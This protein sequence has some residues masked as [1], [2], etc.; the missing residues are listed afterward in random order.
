MPLSRKNTA[1]SLFAIVVIIAVSVV[2]YKYRGLIRMKMLEFLHS[3]DDEVAVAE[4][5]GPPGAWWKARESSFAGSDSLSPLERE[6][7]DLLRSIGYLPGYEEAPVDFGVTLYD[8][9]LTSD[10]Y[11]LIISGHGPGISLVDMN[12]EEVHT[13]FN[14]SVTIDRLWPEAQ[15]KELPFEFWRRAHLYPN[16]DLL[17]MIEACGIIL[18]NKDSDLLWYSQWN[19]AHHD[20]DID[21]EGNIYTIGRY[22]HEN[23][24]Y[25]PDKIIAEDYIIRLD[26]LGNET[27]RLST[28]DVLASSRYAPVL[29]DMPDGGDVLHCN[30]IEF[31]RPDMLP[32]GYSGPFRPGSV[33]LSHRTIDLVCA[34]D[35]E[36]ETVYWAE[37]DLWDMQ[38]Q[39][40]LMPDGTMMVLDNQGYNHLEEEQSTVIQFDPATGERIWY[41]QGD[42]EHPFYTIGSGS[43]QRLPNGNT[44]IVESM[45]GRAFEVTPDKQIVWEFYNPHR[46]GENN[47]L[48]ATLFDLVR[49]PSSS[50]DGWLE[51]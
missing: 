24:D 1:I 47:E 36:E 39:P 22:I 6:Q 51:R 25:F 21:G 33:L 15:D 38:H 46:A 9:S 7:I 30:T 26:S 49:I 19:G 20:V 35:L 41:Y 3:F 10:G 14:S 45:M 2:G 4:E 32:E 5:E 17:V 28:L 40:N 34:V 42:S 44:L 43:C 31:I 27:L 12:G 50:V 23:S 8:T 48:I 11:N 18:V 13:W 37:S 16:G 29:R